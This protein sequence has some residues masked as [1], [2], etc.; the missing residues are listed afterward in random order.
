RVL[1]GRCREEG[2][3]PA[4]WPWVQVLRALAREIDPTT[5]SA[6]AGRGAALLGAAVPELGEHL[7]ASGL[8]DSATA[9]SRFAFF[10]AVE[11]FL[12]MRSASAPLVLIFDDLHAADPS[13][14]ALLSFIAPEL[15]H[16]RVLLLAT[17]REHEASLN[18]SG[19]VIARAVRFGARVRLTGL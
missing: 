4:H 6:A 1:W 7:G 3:T 13:S 9:G 2:G 8:A 14:L 16:A 15:A 5:L 11:A 17:Y 19:P 10:D 18:E 12:R